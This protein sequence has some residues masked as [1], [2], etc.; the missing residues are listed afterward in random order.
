MN[1]SLFC[2]TLL[3]LTDVVLCRT[4]DLSHVIDRN[5]FTPSNAPTYNWTVLSRGQSY[6]G[7]YIESGAYSVGEHVGTH[8]DAP[9]HFVKGSKTL[10]QLTIEDTI[11]EGVMIDCSEEARQDRE[12]QVTLEKILDWETKHGRIP[13]QAAVIFNF[14]WSAKFGNPLEYIG[15]VTGNISNIVF[16]SVS[17]AA[18]DFLLHERDVKIIGTDTRSP[19]PMSLKGKP[20]PRPH[21]H[22]TYLPRDRLIVENLKG[23]D[24]LPAKNFR[25]FANPTKFDRGTGGQVRA[26]A[27]T[28][29]PKSA[30]NDA[31][32]FSAIS[33]L[34]GCLLSVLFCTYLLVF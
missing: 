1:P 6:E 27:M 21:I 10:E 29:D 24:Q 30:E 11:A 32:K 15:D 23:T 9:A 7:V 16:P 14:G 28:F 8:I 31:P 26:F 2:W 18:A 25:F 19:D 33:C 13:D 17:E 3:I 22:T 5:S 4:I 34:I 20:L 12:Y